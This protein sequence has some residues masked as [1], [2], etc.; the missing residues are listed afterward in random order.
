[1]TKLSSLLLIATAALALT[2]CAQDIRYELE[3]DAQYWQRIDTT[4]MI[5][6]RGPK[7]QQML[8][9]DIARCTTEL[10]EMERLGALRNTIPDDAYGNQEPP[11]P[12]SPDSRMADWDSPERQGYL[13][14]EHYPYSDFE[15]CMTYK[16]WERTRYIN[17]DTQRRSWNDY[18][19]AVGVER[20]RTISG[21]RQKQTGNNLNN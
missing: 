10:K 16:G 13:Y 9:R 19:D 3:T 17:T 6:Q 8:F 4:D 12:G 5:Y 14:A 11:T 2:A 1:M 21:E 15:T 20:Y 7:A 18:L